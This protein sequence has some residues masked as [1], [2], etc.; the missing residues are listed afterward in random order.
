MNAT[1]LQLRKFIR[2]YNRWHNYNGHIFAHW[3]VFLFVITLISGQISNRISNLYSRNSLNAT[4]G[5][6]IS[7]MIT[8]SG[9]YVDS[10]GVGHDVNVWGVTNTQ[11]GETDYFTLALPSVT[12]GPYPTIVFNDPYSVFPSPPSSNP[13][14]ILWQGLSSQPGP[15]YDVSLPAQNRFISCSTPTGQCPISVLGLVPLSNFASH[16]DVSF[17]GVNYSNADWALTNGYAVAISFA[18]FYAGRDLVTYVTGTEN[19]IEVLKGMPNIDGQKIGLMGRSLGGELSVHPLAMPARPL[20]I[21]ATVAEA[22][23]IDVRAVYNYYFGTLPAIQPPSLYTQSHDFSASYLNRVM[24]FFGPDPN[25]SRWDPITINPIASAFNTPILLLHSSE[26]MMVPVTEST[27]F[28]TALKTLGKTASKWIYQ[29]GPPPLTTKSPTEGGHGIMDANSPVKRRILARN[30]FLKYMPPNVP[31]VVYNIPSD[32]DLIAMLSSFRNTVCSLPAEKENIS[33]LITQAANPKIKYQGFSAKV[34]TGNGPE[35]VA[36]AINS[37]WSKEGLAWTKD[38]V[39]SNLSSGLL[40]TDCGTVVVNPI[41]PPVPPVPPVLPEPPL[42]ELP[43]TPDLI[44]KVTAPPTITSE[45]NSTSVVP[46]QRIEIDG[47]NLSDKIILI[48]ATGVSMAVQGFVDSQLTTATFEVPADIAPGTYEVIITNS[49]GSVTSTQGLT[50]KVGGEPF[51]NPNPTSV[52]PPTQDSPTNL[53]QFIQQIFA[54]SLGILGIAVFVVFF[55]SGFL[56][57]TAAG[58]TARTGDAKSHMTNA[59]FGAILLLS[60]YLILYTINPDFIKNTV[61]LPGLGEASPTTATPPIACTRVGRDEQDY[62]IPL[63]KGGTPPQDVAT[64][65]NKQFNLTTGGEAV[66]YSDSN[67]IGLPE[68][69]AAGPTNKPDSPKE[70]GIVSRCT[71]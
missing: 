52:A 36:S 35:V 6:A 21:A 55:Y 39:M 70:W 57:L 47:A 49:K 50:V 38:N 25:S 3:L 66:Y 15:Y 9:R 12:S 1:H 22:P 67:T 32:V 34:P 24:A 61:N 41:P 33:G 23:W 28:Y 62:M 56:Y 54:W 31:E 14:D 17:E 53:G 46:G 40:P 19:V 71:P 10:R 13:E 8:S 4:I 59:V 11:S 37:V 51:S 20:S 5:S 42:P 18:R 44:N 2:W 30:F 16:G 63:L 48:T 68:F 7:R 43:I 27:N 65:T 58:N 29:N 69:Y 60:S 26:D 45:L 64:M